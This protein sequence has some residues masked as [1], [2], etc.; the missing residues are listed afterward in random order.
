MPSKFEQNP[1]PSRKATVYKNYLNE[2]LS[3][4]IEIGGR[5]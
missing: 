4:Y 3:K 1:G 2:S 5:I